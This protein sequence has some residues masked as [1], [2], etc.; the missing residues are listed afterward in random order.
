M[1]NLGQDSVDILTPGRSGERNFIR[2]RMR[3]SWMD[4][5]GI[6]SIVRQIQ[7]NQDELINEVVAIG[8]VDSFSKFALSETSGEWFLRVD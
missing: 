1:A 7:T 4:L 8:H 2:L 3:R 6:P 5:Q